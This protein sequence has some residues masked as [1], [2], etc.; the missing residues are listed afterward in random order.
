MREGLLKISKTYLKEVLDLPNDTEIISVISED[1][2]PENIKFFK[3]NIIIRVQG[4]KLEKVAKGEELPVIKRRDL[5]R[6]N[7]RRSN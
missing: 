5:R 1:N 6:N 2:L 3:D 4:S 7:G